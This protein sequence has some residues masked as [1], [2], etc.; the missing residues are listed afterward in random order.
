MINGSE[1]K[2][3]IVLVTSQLQLLSHYHIVGSIHVADTGRPAFV[4]EPH[5]LTR[6]DR[7]LVT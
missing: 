5:L 3:S 1:S 6:T 7:Q 2:I 4:V